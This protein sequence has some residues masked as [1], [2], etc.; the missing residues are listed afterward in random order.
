MSRENVVRAP[1]TVRNGGRRTLDERLALRFPG[2]FRALGRW[3][4]RLPLR[5]RRLAISRQV[6]QG[7]GAA[8]RRDF[9]AVVPRYHPDV[10]ITVADELLGLG[11]IEPTYRGHDGYRKIYSDWLPAWGDSFRFEGGELIVVDNQLVALV[12]IRMRGEGSGVEIARPLAF[13]WTLDQDARI[14]HE[15]QYLAWS[16]AL[17]AVG[18]RE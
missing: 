18:L 14:V 13:R 7:F 12:K 17:E 1:F 4:L 8:N 6:G 11:D 5:L 15:H 9:D 16:D 2:V 10:E 3:T